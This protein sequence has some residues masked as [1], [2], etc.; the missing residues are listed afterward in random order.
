[1]NEKKFR[2][3]GKLLLTGEYFVLDGA[4][5]LALPTI[6]GQ[7]LH[8]EEKEESDGL[9]HWKSFDNEKKMWFEAVFNTQK[10]TILKT[11]NSEVSNTLLQMFEVIKTLNSSIFSAKKDLNVAT[12][13]EFPQ[14]WGLGSSSTLIYTLAKWCEIN[15]YVLLEKT[16]GGSGYDIACA[17]INQAIIYQKKE[18]VPTFQTVNFAPSFSE[19]LYFVHLGKKQNSR[20]GIAKY[21]ATVHK[22]HLAMSELSQLTEAILFSKDITDFEKIIVEH[23]AIISNAL[24]LTCAKDLHFQ[25]YDGAIKS[26]GAWGGDFVLATSQISEAETFAYFHKKG[27]QTVLPYRQIILSKSQFGN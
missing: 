13:L 4:Q 3:N 22:N 24:E 19:N 6:L 17:G 26:L 15:P 18:N 5:A 10:M 25:D 7:E 27:F 12:Y 9:I 1:M 16:M 2:G 14:N 23:E 20:E 21:R 11:N 8:V